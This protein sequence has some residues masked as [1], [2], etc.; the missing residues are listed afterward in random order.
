VSALKTYFESMQSPW[1]FASLTLFPSHCALDPADAGDCSVCD[2]LEYEPDQAR[3]NL[4]VPLTP[5]VGNAAAFGNLLDA[6]Q[7]SGGAPTIAALRGAFAYASRVVAAKAAGPPTS[8][9]LIADRVPGFG[10]ELPMVAWASARA[11]RGQRSGEHHF[12]GTAVP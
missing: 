10:T 6:T 5:I 3:V 7:P 4:Q 11:A 1:T 8:V 12:V 9:V 2:P